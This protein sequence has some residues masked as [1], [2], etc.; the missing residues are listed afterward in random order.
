MEFASREQ[1]IR[2]R[3][4]AIWENEGRPMDRANAHW[5]QA[6]AEIAR[7]EARP[8][9]VTVPMSKR[10]AS[11]KKRNPVGTTVTPAPGRRTRTP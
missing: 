5:L 1:Q 2:E 7:A 9:G 10:A 4:Y 11:M 8:N 3:A 6:E